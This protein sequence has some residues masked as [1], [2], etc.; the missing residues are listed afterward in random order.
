MATSPPAGTRIKLGEPGYFGIGWHTESHHDAGMTAVAECRKRGGGGVC[1]F[2]ASGTSLR[3]GCVGL[4]MAKWRDE[5][6]DQERTY[7]VTS[8]SFRDL[9]DSRLRSD[10]ESTAFG[11]KYHESVVEHSCQIVDIMCAEDI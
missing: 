5:G 4:A 8:S 1:S 6:K 3:G 7:I 10:C 2:N 9:I 11:G